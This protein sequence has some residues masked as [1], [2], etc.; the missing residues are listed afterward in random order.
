MFS[1][2]M[3]MLRAECEQSLA[4][5]NQTHPIFTEMFCEALTIEWKKTACV[6]SLLPHHI[7][8]PS[9]RLWATA[10]FRI[11]FYQPKHNFFVR[12]AHLPKVFYI[13]DSGGFAHFSFPIFTLMFYAH[14][15]YRYDTAEI[16]QHR[17]IALSSTWIKA[18]KTQNGQPPPTA[19]VRR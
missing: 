13:D 1:T 10:N 11:Y 16:A 7:T 17:F 2:T 6:W 3:S 9:F 15:W 4:R 18:K 8:L 19:V 5:L 14:A 12:M